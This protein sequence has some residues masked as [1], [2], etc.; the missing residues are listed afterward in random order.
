MRAADLRLAPEVEGDLRDAFEWYEQHRRGLGEEFLSCVEVILQQVSRTPSRLPRIR[1][2]WR[3][4]IVRRF[5]FA[6]YYRQY[7]E[8]TIFVL[9][10]LH[11]ARHPEKWR[12]R[13]NAP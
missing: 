10:V 9:A 5:P 8:R 11:H 4:A 6:V 12:Q 3:R 1:G 2:A 7:D 13:G